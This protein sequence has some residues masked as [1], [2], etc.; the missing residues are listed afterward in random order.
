MKGGYVCLGFQPISVIMIDSNQLNK[1][2]M[3]CSSIN[4]KGMHDHLNIPKWHIYICSAKTLLKNQI[5]SFFSPTSPIFHSK[6]LECKFLIK[7][8]IWLSLST[9]MF[10]GK[11]QDSS[12]NSTKFG[13]LPYKNIVPSYKTYFILFL[14]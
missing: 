1:F 6:P 5:M 7:K 2:W 3:S 13:D 12:I 8:L 9:H 14:V 10:Y 4:Q 11:I